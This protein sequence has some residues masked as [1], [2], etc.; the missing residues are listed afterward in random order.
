MVLLVLIG[1]SGSMPAGS[2]VPPGWNLPQLSW[3]VA[4]LPTPPPPHSFKDRIDVRHTIAVQ[5]A[6][7][8]ADFRRAIES[9]EFNV[10]SFS[11]SVG[12]NFSADRFPL[13]ARFFEH[14]QGVVDDVTGR[15]KLHYR[16]E[17]LEITHPGKTKL[18]V[19]RP[20]GFAYPSGHTTRAQV[21]ALVLAEL[22]PASRARLLSQAAGIG[23]DRVLTGQHYYSDVATG[24]ILGRLIFREL[25]ADPAFVADLEV[26][27]NSEWLSPVSSSR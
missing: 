20:P 3:F 4:R 19:S 15:L 9:N 12:A 7:G 17:R 21:F 2:S 13:T 5:S 22:R 10:F 1:G 18:L 24:R 8:E 27:K 6:A 23:H 16:R 14:L 26:L 11:P 25:M